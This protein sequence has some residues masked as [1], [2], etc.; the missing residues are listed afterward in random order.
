MV[1]NAVGCIGLNSHCCRNY[2]ER[3]S[4]ANLLLSFALVLWCHH[5]VF[6]KKKLFAFILLVWVFGILVEAIGVST[7]VVFGKY[8]Y[9]SALGIAIFKVPLI[10]GLNWV[11]LTYATGVT[12]STLR[13]PFWVKVN[14]G[15]LLMVLC[16][17]LLEKF[18][19]KHNFW[20]WELTGHPPL[21]NFF[22]W[23]V[24]SLFTITLF[25]WLIPDTRNKLAVFY[26]MALLLFLLTDFLL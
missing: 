12:F 3:L 10:I 13:I 18:A 24:F 8:H 23:W 4:A 17:I 9:T 11:L 6:N 15:A 25:S 2:F 14:A 19:I 5:P 22:A 20:V 21:L 1:F 26:F 7:G 16:D